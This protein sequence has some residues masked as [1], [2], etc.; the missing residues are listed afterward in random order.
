MFDRDQKYQIECEEDEF[1]DKAKDGRW[2][3]M[4]TSSRKGLIGKRKAGTCQGSL[5]CENNTCPKL[6]SEGIPNTNEFT[7]DSGV[8][9]CK[10][11][12]YFVYRQYCSVLKVIEFGP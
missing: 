10:C 3:D 6:L 9:V 4:H 11:C 2:F 12:G 1:I 8:D 7:K 5:M